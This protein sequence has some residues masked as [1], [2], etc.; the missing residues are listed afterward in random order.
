MTTTA[1][2]APRRAAP[3][4]PARSTPSV[5]VASPLGR[6]AFG[7]VTPR[8]CRRIGIYGPGG[9]GKTTL[10]ATAPGPVAFID[11][12]ESLSVLEDLHELDLRPVEASDWKGLR[13]KLTAPGW[14]DIKTIV[15]DPVSKA[16]E[17]CVA[18]VLATVPHEKGHK[19]TRLED[20]GYGKG[21]QYVYDMFLPLLGD[22][23]A[24]IRAGRTVVLVMH[25]CTANVPNPAG[26]DWIRYEPRL[27]SP[28]SGKAS[29][30]LRVKEWLD[31]L[32]FLGYDVA[33][34]KEGKGQG[35]G[36]RTVWPIELPHCMAKSRKL[37]DP[38]TLDKFSPVLWQ[39]LGLVPTGKGA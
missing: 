26:D 23:D 28:A 30:R 31:D 19:V 35:S 22:L 5:P 4:A 9:I 21:Y 34:D 29:V 25:D 2:P 37:T 17:F 10:A 15:I 6:V 38:L 27:Q 24:H 7:K 3:V 11:L 33:V 8:V 14:D 18:E 39:A 13:T 16:E 1:P 20:Y 36:T 12:D 32:L